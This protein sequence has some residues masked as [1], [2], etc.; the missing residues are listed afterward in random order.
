MPVSRRSFLTGASAVVAAAACSRSFAGTT[1]SLNPK[2]G[3]GGV[4]PLNSGLLTS[5]YYNWGINPAARGM[6]AAHSSMRFLPMVWGWNAE[7]TPAVLDA[8]RAT[9]PS[10]LLG[11]NEPDRVDQSNVPVEVALDAWPQFEGIASEL[12]SPAA[13]NAHGPW[14]QEFMKGV[15]KRKLHIDSLAFHS[16]PGPNPEGFLHSLQTLYE[17]YGRPIWVTEFAVADWQAK[18]GGANRYTV[19]QTAEFM[20]T[21]CAEMDKLPWIKGYAWFPSVGD[22]RERAAGSRAL[23]TSLLFDAEGNLTPLGEIYNSL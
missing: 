1:R 15:E 5:W 10:I 17:M 18:H 9:H 16:Y 3:L 7:K 2:K 23:V 21:V 8:L 12:V 13:A 11:F 19:R 20:K 22:K 6:P 14:M 4:A